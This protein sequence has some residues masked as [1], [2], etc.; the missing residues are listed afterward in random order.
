MGAIELKISIHQLV[1]RIQNEELL[2]ALYDFLKSRES[3]TPGAI[4]N[5]LTEEQKREVLLAYEE[6]EE[7]ENLIAREAIFRKRK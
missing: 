4:W 5:S 2:Q 1:E 6:S 7:E 3:Q